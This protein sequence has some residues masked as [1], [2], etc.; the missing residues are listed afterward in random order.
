MSPTLQLAI[1]IAILLPATKIAATV[2]DR[3]GVPAIVGELMVGVVAGP[4]ILNLLHWPIFHG[5]QAP[6]ALTILAQIGGV[7]LMFIAGLETDVE[8]MREASFTATLVAIS[9]VVWPMLLGA[10]VAH[11]MG[12]G[13]KPALFLGGA[14]TATSVSISARTLM[15]AGKMVS[16]EASV[17]LGAAV[18]DDVLG[19]FVLAFLAASC[20]SGG[21]SSSVS[22]WITDQL[23]HHFGV[24]A[25]FPLTVQMIAI[26]LCVVVYFFLG[27]AGARK[28]L[29]PLILYM[30]K[31]TAEEAVPACVFAL[32]L[33]YA[34]TAEWLGSVAAI[35]G[36]YLIGF[37]FAESKLKAYVE[38]SFYALGHGLF[39]PLFFVS[40][41]LE[42]DVRALQGHWMMLGVLFVVGVLTKLVGCGAAAM[43][44]GMGFIPSLR[45]G[46]G[47]ISRGEVGLIITV[48]AAETGIFL[49]EEVA[50]M[51]GVVLLT[52]LFTPFALRYAFS[53]PCNQDLEDQAEDALEQAT[54]EGLEA[55]ELVERT[56][57]WPPVHDD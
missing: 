20:H 47:M 27:Y 57:P 13:W 50:V 44:D 51:V 19:L 33:V 2:C 4:G 18:I 21:E 55:E 1:L 52:T 38:R 34:V 14:L 45:V 25:Q 54:I 41:G 15:D 3:Y 48:M 30:R 32:V 8:R 22:S 42:S 11:M 35:T 31:L 7:V 43:V 40:I 49:P 37:I 56:P 10:G 12:L 36:S 5:D 53:L 28:F 26:A 9:G 23:T 24:A 39:I 17:I 6:H 16:R 29:D 46:C